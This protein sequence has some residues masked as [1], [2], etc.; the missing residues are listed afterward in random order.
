M[1]I[2][3]EE[4]VRDPTK[5]VELAKQRQKVLENTEEIFHTPRKQVSFETLDDQWPC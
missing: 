4:L 2:Q 5:V 1:H 3:N